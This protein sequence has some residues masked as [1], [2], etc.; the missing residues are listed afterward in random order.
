MTCP[1]LDSGK[2]ETTTAIYSLGSRYRTVTGQAAIVGPEKPLLR[3]YYYHVIDAAY[4]VF[5]LVI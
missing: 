3:Q 1:L 5:T 4:Q 2:F